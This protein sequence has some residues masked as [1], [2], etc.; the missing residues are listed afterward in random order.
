MQNSPEYIHIPQLLSEIYRKESRFVFATLIRLLGDFDLAEDATHD[1]FKAALEQWGTKGIPANPRAWLVSTGRFKA[2]DSMRRQSKFDPL[3]LQQIRQLEAETPDPS[4]QVD[5]EIEDDVLRLIFTCCHP[6]LSLEAQTAMTLREVCELTTEEISR[7]FLLTPSTLAQRIVRAKT[8]IRQ[9][10]IPFEVPAEQ[11]L[12]DRLEAILQIIYLLFNEGY[13]ASSGESLTRVN[14][15][16]EAIRLGRLLHNLL[17][18]PQVT[19]LLALMLLQESRRPARTSSTGDVIL[20]EDQDRSLWDHGMIEEGLLLVEHAFASKRLSPYTLQ[21]GIAALHA[22][23]KNPDGTDWAQI[24]RLYSLLLRINPSP[25]IELNRAVA[26]AMHKGPEAGLQQINAILE[27]GKLNDYHL[28]HAAR[29]EL[30]RKIGY[31]NQARAS[32]E[33]A[34]ALAQQDPER[35]FIE[36]KLKELGA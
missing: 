11:E 14:L 3:Q 8:K 35:R 15:S 31:T 20:L 4:G 28:A 21:A 30:Y 5:K 16:S 6:A 33:R 13:Y 26:I 36:R 9:A 7:A 1:A 10:K 19:G 34:L 24:T 32:W 18:D 27:R 12:P 17:P 2:I 29:A 22:Q 23:A 25:V